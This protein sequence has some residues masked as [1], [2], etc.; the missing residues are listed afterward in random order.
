MRRALV[1]ARRLLD[2]RADLD[3]FLAGEEL[4]A[5]Q[6]W[7]VES[8]YTLSVPELS[9][10]V[11]SI[12]IVLTPKW[13]LREITFTIDQKAYT[14]PTTSAGMGKETGPEAV[15]ERLAAEGLCAAYA[16]NLPSKR[17]AVCAGL[18]AYGRNNIAYAPGMGSF[19][20]ILP[21]FTD[22]VC[23]KDPWRPLETMAL[24]GRCE[25]CV[26]ACPTGAIRPDR[27]LIDN[28]RC[29]TGVNEYL[30]AEEF[31]DWIPPG[32]HHLVGECLKCQRACPVNAPFFGNVGPQV[33]FDE[34]ET[35]ALMGRVPYGE[36]PPTLREKI[37]DLEWKK[38]L[39][40]IPRN[41]RALLRAG[42]FKE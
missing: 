23:E 1:P 15:A 36:M 19:F 22:A 25:S 37:D 11:R 20:R 26:A 2:L 29:L 27:F 24:C 16:P 32:A 5:F 21:F 3:G 7:I 8:L 14:F 41:V 33:R 17:L 4:N 9:C 18:A 6:R 39:P 34:A 42:G 31:P 10:T 40:V 13:V 38:Y 30:G 12:L 35:A 28:R